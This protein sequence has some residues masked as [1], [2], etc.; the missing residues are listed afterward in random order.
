MRIIPGFNKS[1]IC[2]MPLG[3]YMYMYA[4]K[5]NK[6]KKTKPSKITTDEEYWHG[7]TLY[8][9]IL[10]CTLSYCKNTCNIPVFYKIV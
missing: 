8:T 4:L 1:D 2:I 3:I 9:V 5:K 7:H 10:I 6:N